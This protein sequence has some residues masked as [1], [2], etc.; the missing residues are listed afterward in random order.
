MDVWAVAVVAFELLRQPA[1]Q[2][3]VA[4][5]GSKHDVRNCAY[6]FPIILR[7]LASHLQPFL[8]LCLHSQS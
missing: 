4:L 5:F 7:A 3:G 1:G 8:R 2:H 6:K